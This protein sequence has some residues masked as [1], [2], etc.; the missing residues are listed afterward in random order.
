MRFQAE[1]GNIV[2]DTDEHPR[3]DV[4]LEGLGKLKTVFKENGTVTAGNSSGMNDGASGVL[5]MSE[6]KAKELGVPILAKILSVA[7]TGVDADIMGIGPV[8]A[9]QK[10]LD[11]AMLTI[12]DIELFEINEA[13]AAQYLACEKELGID[14]NITNVNGSGISLGHAVGASGSR[15]VVSLIYEM[16]KRNNRYGLASLCAGG[17]M[18]TAIVLEMSN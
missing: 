15:L 7:T 10:A 1:K 11:K 3:K 8:S 13:F 14:R 17:G 4:T 18:G 6:D 9:S 5:L 12:K 16:K 2:I